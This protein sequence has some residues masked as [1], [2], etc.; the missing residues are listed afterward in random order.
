MDDVLD[1][2]PEVIIG[3]P[4]DER[5]TVHRTGMLLYRLLA[6][7]RP[8]ATPTEHTMMRML[9]AA[10]EGERVSI[11]SVRPDLPEA[12][13][14]VVDDAVALDRDRR[15]ADLATLTAH[16][17]RWLEPGY[18]QDAASIIAPADTASFI[19]ALAAELFPRTREAQLQWW[20][21]AAMVDV[22][23]PVPSPQATPLPVPAPSVERWGALLEELAAQANNNAVT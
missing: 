1:M 17:R 14:A 21:E 16:W 9:R 19:A 13:A 3:R 10:Y 20:D 6:G 4:A 15:P 8:W 7:A 22:D 23:V 12:V 18:W 2:A 11:R 5:A